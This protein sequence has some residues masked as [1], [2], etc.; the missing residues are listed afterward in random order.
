MLLLT[1][2]TDRLI[3][4]SSRRYIT[5]PYLQYLL[6]ILSYINF[7]DTS[8]SSTPALDLASLARP[9]TLWTV[10]SSWE[11]FWHNLVLGF[12]CTKSI[13]S[14]EDM[15]RNIIGV[16]FLPPIV[17]V[18]KDNS[19]LNKLTSFYIIHRHLK[20]VYDP[21]LIV[22]RVCHSFWM[23]HTHKENQV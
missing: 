14:I 16:G 3:L 8:H 18:E 7:K 10:S 6:P 5:W 22:H 1:L 9:L 12:V 19:T 17:H 15:H 23:Q 20:Q 4:N 21:T 11:R 13:V 2:L